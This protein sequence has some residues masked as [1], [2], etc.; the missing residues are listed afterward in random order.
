[1]VSADGR[2]HGHDRAA[3]RTGAHRALDPLRIPPQLTGA[4]LRAPNPATLVALQRL[5]GNRAVAG[6]LRPGHVTA[7]ATAPANGVDLPGHSDDPGRLTVQRKFGFEFQSAN[8]FVAA[9]GIAPVKEKEEVWVN[10]TGQVSLEGDSADDSG[11]D[12]E[13]ITTAT[14]DVKDAL[15]AVGKASNLARSLSKK[16]DQTYQKDSRTAG[17]SWKRDVA[18]KVSDPNFSAAVQ[19]T[20]GIPLAEIELLLH[21]VLVKAPKQ[22]RMLRGLTA[23]TGR[24]LTFKDTLEK[25]ESLIGSQKPTPGTA[26]DGLLTFISYY[27]S[28]G[29]FKPALEMKKARQQDFWN[30]KKHDST[31][32]K[33]LKEAP[34]DTYW[35]VEGPTDGPKALF[36]LMHRTNLRKAF[37]SLS[38]TERIKFIRIVEGSTD[39]KRKIPEPPYYAD[40]EVIIH[41]K[42]KYPKIWE[43]MKVG[44]FEDVHKKPFFIVRESPTVFQWLAS[45]IQDLKP[46]EFSEEEKRYI[47][48]RDLMS[49]PLG[50]GRSPAPSRFPTKEEIRENAIYGMGAYPMDTLPKGKS[51]NDESSDDDLFIVE[52]RGLSQS[53]RED[54]SNSPR[55]DLPGYLEWLNV[56]AATIH[57]HFAGLRGMPPLPQS[58]PVRPLNPTDH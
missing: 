58:T 34:G 19:A 22:G 49:P 15:E 8:R 4:K 32:M 50:Y 31:T 20:I 53:I 12:L 37:E 48:G 2:R 30:S 29:T 24:E 55:E 9:D 17:G 43:L 51:G 18:I 14:D 41:Y 6:H 26:L 47:K 28:V 52:F 1:M 33:F 21:N 39:D 10:D 54:F 35:Q 36:E 57:L 56:A 44:K 11:S 42:N 5:A 23:D 46:E 25:K 38:P 7:R 3:S 27:I 45:M 40:P 13:F 16:G